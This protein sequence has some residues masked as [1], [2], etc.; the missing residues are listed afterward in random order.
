MT[1]PLLPPKKFSVYLLLKQDKLTFYPTGVN[2]EMSTG[3]FRNRED[4]E[5][6][7]MVEVLKGTSTDMYHIYELEVPNPAYRE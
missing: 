1:T 2:T 7:R 5:H 6:Q 4:A 3:F